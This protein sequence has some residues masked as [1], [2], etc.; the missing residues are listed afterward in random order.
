M[1]LAAGL[2]ASVAFAGC[3]LTQLQNTQTAAQKFQGEVTAAC[4]VF[5]PAIAPFAPF[6]IG[7]AP[8]TAFNSDVALACG[9]NALVNLT[10]INNVINS[11]AAAAK[12]V[13]PQFKHL[14]PE[15]V[16]LVQGLIGAFEGSLRNA[17]AAYQA[18]TG[19]VLTTAPAVTSAVASSPVAAIQ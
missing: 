7:N 8:V 13:I 16:A 12:A 4:N 1:L 3:T 11:S 18:S 17:I 2:V 6:F 9:S 19:A 10:S 5:Q 14:T 15:Q